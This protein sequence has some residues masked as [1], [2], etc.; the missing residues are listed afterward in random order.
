MGH[1]KLIGSRLVYISRDLYPIHSGF[2]IL[3]GYKLPFSWIQVASLVSS[4]AQK[5]GYDD[6]V[7]P[8]IGSRRLNVYPSL[9]RIGIQT[10]GGQDV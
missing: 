10:E 4:L 8:H 7:F 2:P 9:S 1:H 6:I 3:G 5:I